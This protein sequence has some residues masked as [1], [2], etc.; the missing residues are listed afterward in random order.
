MR[1]WKHWGAGARIAARKLAAR[2][3]QVLT[4]EPGQTGA[5]AGARVA[6]PW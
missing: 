6:L 2:A 5:G 4:T 3:V 1:S